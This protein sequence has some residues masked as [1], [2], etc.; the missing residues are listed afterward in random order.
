MGRDMGPVG[1]DSIWWEK[2]L[3]QVAFGFSCC[4]SSEH[5]SQHIWTAWNSLFY[6]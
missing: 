3:E 4:G 6:L 1:R 2:G 5:D